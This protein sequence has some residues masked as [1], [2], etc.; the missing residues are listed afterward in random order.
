M[1]AGT[2]RQLRVLLADGEETYLGF[3]VSM[4]LRLGHVVVAK[5]MDLEM[6]AA[7]SE[8]APPDVAL[9]VVGESSERALGLIRTIVREATCPAIVLLSVEDAAFVEEA[10]RCGVFAYIANGTM[11]DDQLEGAIS[12]VLHL[13]SD[14]R[15]QQPAH[16]DA[17]LA[18]RIP[19]IRAIPGRSRH[20]SRTTAPR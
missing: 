19:P 16:R 12:V 8:H 2:G 18:R 15:S 5:A 6:V 3:V 11:S 1:V 10:A 7:L 9:V 14:R 4:V 13:L 17:A 20:R